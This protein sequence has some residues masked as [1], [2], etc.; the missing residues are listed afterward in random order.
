MIIIIACK[1]IKCS[2][3]MTSLRNLLINKIKLIINK[4]IWSYSTLVKLKL[5]KDFT[6]KAILKRG[7][8]SLHSVD[9]SIVGQVQR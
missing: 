7:F 2:M 5:V 9:R 8:F 1:F 6:V 4:T 3:H